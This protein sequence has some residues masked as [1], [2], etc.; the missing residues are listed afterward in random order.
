MD[1][2]SQ[3]ICTK[4]KGVD[5]VER[6]PPFA[7]TCS[8]VQQS[9]TKTAKEK[10]PQ[11]RKEQMNALLHMSSSTDFGPQSKAWGGADPLLHVAFAT[12]V[13]TTR[14]EKKDADIALLQRGA[15]TTSKAS[16]R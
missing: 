4:D 15:A 6:H 14:G 5:Q 12:G 1:P 13:G 10:H 16:H 2:S 8:L 7:R 11:A 9:K 3:P